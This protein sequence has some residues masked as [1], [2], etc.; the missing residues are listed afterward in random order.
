MINNRVQIG[1]AYKQTC[2]SL[3]NGNPVGAAK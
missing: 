1:L 2:H 3:E